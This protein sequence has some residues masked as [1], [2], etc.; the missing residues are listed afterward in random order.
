MISLPVP[1]H[2]TLALS[3]GRDARGSKRRD[4]QLQGVDHFLEGT[5]ESGRVT[6]APQQGFSKPGG[7]HVQILRRDDLSA[8]TAWN[9]ILDRERTKLISRKADN[10]PKQIYRLLEPF[11]ARLAAAVES[12]F[13]GPVCLLTKAF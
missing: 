3:C 7:A 8:R 10:D 2:Q 5:S 9:R 1:A 4:R 11:Q 13:K 12:T 6:L